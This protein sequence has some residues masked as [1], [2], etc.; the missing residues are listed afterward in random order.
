MPDI[1]KV[2][3][4][5]PCETAGTTFEYL[6]QV[7][8]RF[9]D[10]LLVTPLHSSSS[11]DLLGDFQLLP[12]QI[13]TVARVQSALGRYGGALLANDV[14]SGKTLVALAVARHYEHVHIIA[15]VT[16]LP[17]WRITARKALPNG[18]PVHVHSLARYSRGHHSPLSPSTHTLVIVD[19]AHHLRNPRTA[20]YG[21]VAR[22]TAGLD[23]LLLSAT[24][25]HNRAEDLHALCALFLPPHAVPGPPNPSHTLPEAAIIRA[26]PNQPSARRC[27]AFAPGVSTQ[28]H[29]DTPDG[30]T[31]SPA[32]GLPTVRTHRPQRIPQNRDT[33]RHI[34]AL[35]P[36][37]P[38]HQGVA[39]AALV[40]LGLL[41]AWCSSDA[42]LARALRSRRLRSEALRDALHTGRHPSQRELAS[43]LTGDEHGQLG[44]PEIL[45]AFRLNADET[46]ATMLK[47]LESHLHAINTLA[48]HHATHAES[49]RQRLQSLRRILRRHPDRPVIAFSQFE[50]TITALHRAMRNTPGIGALTGKRGYI[51]SGAIERHELLGLFAPHAQGRAPPAPHQAV[52]LLLTTDLLAEGV[53]LQDAGVVVHL[54]LPWTDALR[55]QRVGRCARLGSPFADIHVYRL[56]PSKYVAQALRVERRVLD[57]ARLMRQHIAG[58]RPRPSKPEAESALQDALASWYRPSTP[59]AWGTGIAVAISRSQARPR[60]HGDRALVLLQRPPAGSTALPT[61][62]AQASHAAMLLHVAPGAATPITRNPR[63]LLAAVRSVESG[64]DAFH[65]DRI[66]Q[67]VH[68]V[69]RRT[70]SWLERQRLSRSIGQQGRTGA[71]A[72]LMPASTRAQEQIPA[73]AARLMQRAMTSLPVQERRRYGDLMATIR[74]SIDHLRGAGALDAVAD[75]CD[76]APAFPHTSCGAVQSWLLAWNADPVRTRLPPLS[77][78]PSQAPHDSTAWQ[79]SAMILLMDHQWD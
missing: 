59:R 37:L 14:G 32:V 23:L 24:P 4:S 17:M 42:A 41:R 11:H 27:P 74:H 55:A 7:Q 51:A 56:A 61:H 40:R 47:T 49:D 6:E 46:S 28:R 22:A 79:I 58:T 75:W 29:T 1:A 43:W 34:L 10:A 21:A 78:P 62:D 38:A 18:P 52:R 26:A 16:L 20:R 39:A 57:K 19:E 30:R 9:A 65:P 63:R 8:H 36:P 35:P 44:F 2:P 60:S 68:Q 5:A 15:P 33:L 54:D 13:A 72:A 66:N 53:N 31:P 70:S 77:T 25:L 73:R 45:I 71:S 67:L 69:C 3:T 76:Q 12:T 50:G 48:Q 64:T